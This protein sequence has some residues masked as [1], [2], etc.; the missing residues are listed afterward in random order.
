MTFVAEA[1]AVTGTGPY[2]LVAALSLVV[3]ACGGTD[4]ESNDAPGG[5][6]GGTGGTAAVAT[7]PLSTLVCELEERSSAA[8]PPTTQVPDFGEPV[9]LSLDDPCPQ[10]AVEV[11]PDGNRVYYSYSTNVLSV[12]EA[13][14]R[15]FEQVEVRYQDREDGDSWSPPRVLDLK[16]SL[17]GSVP[18]EIRVAPDG[19]WVVWHAIAAQNLG[20]V[21]GLPAG[22]T[23]DLD[24]YDAQIVNGIPGPAR[25]LPRGI[26]SVYLDG[27]H[28]LTDDGRTLYLASD[29]PGG[30]GGVDIWRAERA[31][32]DDWT[33]PVALPPPV[34]STADDLQPT[35]SPDGDWLYMASDRGGATSIWRVPIVDDG[36]GVEAELVLAP[37]VGEP[38]FTDDGRLF[39]VS[40]EIDFSVE[41][42]AL[43]D[44][45][46]YY[47]EPRG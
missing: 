34:N 40:V 7:A 30:V 32:G 8:E 1:G 25:H 44:S 38:S 21:E 9:R 43:F 12:L 37:Y 13:E 27:E 26:N 5:A 33:E 22:Q 41:P 35:L 4:K 18:G 46:I 2:R 6:T 28:W 31:A 17:P 15:M 10:D 36:F 45:D 14:G 24:L 16:T 39:F 29:R 42:P 20:V 3:M 11:S 19:S 47:V 23:F